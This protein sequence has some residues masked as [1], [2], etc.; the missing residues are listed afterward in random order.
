MNKKQFQ[1]RLRGDEEKK[2]C[3]RIAEAPHRL[4]NYRRLARL[5]TA[6]DD[7][8]AALYILNLAH[9]RSPG[10]RELV[11]QIARACEAA[12]RWK[13]AE[14]LYR[15]LIKEH[16]DKS[17]AYERL[18]RLLLK[19]NRYREAA[20]VWKSVDPKSKFRRRA[21]S[22]AAMIYKNNGNPIQ[23]RRLLKKLIKEFGDDFQKLKDIG[24][25]YEKDGK[26]AEAV[27]YYERAWRIKPDHA[28]TALM[29]G[30][31]CRKAGRRKKARRIFNRILEFSPAYYGA[32]IH[33][34]EMAIEDGEYEKAKKLLDRLETRW[35]G[36]SRI[37]INRGRILLEENRLEEAEK[38]CREGLDAAPFYYTDELSLGHSALAA[39][40]EEKGESAEAEYYR[41]VGERCR[42]GGEFY[43]IMVELIEELIRED[44]I[45]TAERAVEGMLSQFPENSLALVLKAR[46]HRKKNQWE[47][48]VEAARAA[49]RENNP[50]YAKDR[51][52]ALRLLNELY[53]GRNMTKKA[54]KAAREAETIVNQIKGEN[55]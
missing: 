45:D 42:E 38:L 1:A 8:E 51:I 20:A 23:A 7:T 46:L 2:T 41:L 9:R 48:A 12:G 25:L 13:R 44:R 39:I 40:L 11:H 21:L 18:E 30:V 35:P 54:E 24:R 10:D 52:A 16:P 36:N 53:A 37:K 50:R 33:L 28:D 49:A 22:R 19:R 5:L 27:K 14:N 32:H 34:A 26:R 3:D 31:C 43:R 15:K 47:K 4:S 17:P 55:A 29:A 6:R